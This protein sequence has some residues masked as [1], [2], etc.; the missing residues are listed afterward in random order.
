[1]TEKVRQIEHKLPGPLHR[2][3]GSGKQTQL[4]SYNGRGVHFHF[5]T[6]TIS[7]ENTVFH[8]VGVLQYHYSQ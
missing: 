4:L 6:T 2:D 7:M 1:M 3:K 8:T 5:I